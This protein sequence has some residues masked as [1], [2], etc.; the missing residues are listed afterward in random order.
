MVMPLEGIR[1]LDMAHL[2]PSSFSSMFLGDMGADVIK[3]QPPRSVIPFPAELADWGLDEEKWAA[4]N[5]IDRNKKSISLDLKKEEARVIVYKLVETT[6]VVIEGFRPGVTERLGVDYETLKKINPRLIYCSE[7]GYGHSGPYTDQVGHDI[8][9]IATAG[10][11]SIIGTQNGGPIIP[12]NIIADYAGAGLHGVIG[13]LLALM[14]REKTRKGQYVDITYLEG[15]LSPMAWQIAMYL[16]TGKEPKRGD[17]WLTGAAP[18]YNIYLTKDDK[19]ISIGCLEPHFWVSLCQALELEQYIPYQYDQGEKRDEV[20]A[21]LRK[22]FRTQ[23][24]DEWYN[25]LGN[26]ICVGKV[27]DIG[28]V[29]VDPQVQHRNMVLEVE[30][31]GLHLHLMSGYLPEEGAQDPL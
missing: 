29:V 6:D 7:S 27:N 11:L 10:V 31:P 25:L 5:P 30:H 1:V 15:A 20:F 2:P 9:Y 3:I 17:S 13:I 24:R 19:Y 23:T 21:A 14:A 22:I 28:E 4:Y 26:E 8:N 12:S 18:F 16:C